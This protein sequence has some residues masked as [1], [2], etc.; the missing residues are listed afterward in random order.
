MRYLLWTIGGD[1]LEICTRSATVSCPLGQRLICSQPALEFSNTMFE[2]YWNVFVFHVKYCKCPLSLACCILVYTY[3]SFRKDIMSVYWEMSFF[4]V[5]GGSGF[6]PSKLLGYIF[7]IELSY[8]CK[9]L[10]KSRMRFMWRSQ[11]WKYFFI[12]NFVIVLCEPT[13]TV[14]S[15]T[16]AW[17]AVI[18]SN[19]YG[20]EQI[21]MKGFRTKPI[22]IS[23]I[24][25][26]GG[27]FSWM[28]SKQNSFV[29]WFAGNALITTLYPA[30]C[31][32]MFGGR[33]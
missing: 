15:F 3:V 22:Y 32:I 18:F 30:S 27:A 6:E 20:L 9:L 11:A 23:M 13:W 1:K 14:T 31:S 8:K 16:A 2:E 28:I 12:N 10:W 17:E 26:H 4:C 24:T 29:A 25:L 21:T 19:N 7:V 5:Y 33:L